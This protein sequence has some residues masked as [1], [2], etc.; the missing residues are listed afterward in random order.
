MTAPRSSEGRY[1][2]FLFDVVLSRTCFGR[3]GGQEAY[4]TSSNSFFKI[5]G[6]E[7][8]DVLRGEQSCFCAAGKGK[9]VHKSGREEHGSDNLIV[10]LFVRT[11]NKEI[12]SEL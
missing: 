8:S 4:I 5:F 2:Q 7:N 6:G 3:E 10:W 11:E 9:K 12:E 1:R